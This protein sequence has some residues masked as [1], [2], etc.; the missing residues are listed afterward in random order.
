MIKVN[1]MPDQVRTG[2]RSLLRKK[3]IPI[4]TPAPKIRLNLLNAKLSKSKI[5]PVRSSYAVSHIT[6]GAAIHAPNN[7]QRPR[8][9]VNANTI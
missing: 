4:T 9:A 2:M 6:K 5:R 3:T 1:A 8:S 7:H